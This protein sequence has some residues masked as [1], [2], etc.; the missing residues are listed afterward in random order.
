MLM[1]SRHNVCFEHQ[2]NVVRSVINYTSAWLSMLIFSDQNVS[3]FADIWSTSNTVSY[4]VL[5][6]DQTA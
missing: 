6:A 5:N 2:V 4:S 1:L 3:S